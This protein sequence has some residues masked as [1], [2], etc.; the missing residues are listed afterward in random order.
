MGI[1]TCPLSYLDLSS[2]CHSLAKDNLTLVVAIHLF[3]KIKLLVQKSQ[4]QPSQ[5]KIPV[6]KLYKERGWGSW[7]ASSKHQKRNN[8]GRW[9]SSFKHF[10]G[11]LGLMMSICFVRKNWEWV[12]KYQS[13]LKEFL[14]C[15][16]VL[17]FWSKLLARWLSFAPELQAILSQI[18]LLVDC[19]VRR[20]RRSCKNCENWWVLHKKRNWKQWELVWDG[21]DLDCLEDLLL[22][23]SGSIV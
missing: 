23:Q 16:F 2:M 12:V 7:I 3:H 17:F 13:L 6:T 20:R 4:A 22:L 8:S 1:V 11:N 18:Q 14:C 10:V 21:D 19:D 9:R 15:N 5:A